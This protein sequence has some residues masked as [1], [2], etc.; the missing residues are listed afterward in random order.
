M[1]K[2]ITTSIRLTP[3]LRQQLDYL[4]RSLHRGKNWIVI[5]ALQE[6]IQKN[7]YTFLAEEAK[8]QSLL[9]SRYETN[10][11]EE[12]WEKNIDITGWQS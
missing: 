2:G 9:A 12:I 3:E 4:S 7:N 5:H 11:D 6:F 8:R 1:H 10:E